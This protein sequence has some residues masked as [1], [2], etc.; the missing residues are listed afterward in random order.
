MKEVHTA[1]AAATISAL[2]AITPAQAEPGRFDPATGVFIVPEVDVSGTIFYDV[3]F[4]MGVDSRFSLVDYS[5]TA[6]GTQSGTCTLDNINFNRYVTLPSF[7]TV[8]TKEQLDQL[9]GCTGTLNSTSANTSTIEWHLNTST[10]SCAQYIY[11]EL[12]LTTGS[13]QQIMGVGIVGINSEN[14]QPKPC[15]GSN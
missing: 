14:N 4:Q 1:L 7:Y 10:P 6:P 11:A 8:V 3:R 9:I 5:A 15:P 13:Q 2:L 12:N